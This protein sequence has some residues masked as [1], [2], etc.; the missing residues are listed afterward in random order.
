MNDSRLAHARQKI[1]ERINSITERQ[2][3]LELERVAIVT[4]LAGFDAAINI[5]HS[6]QPAEPGKKAPEFGS[7]RG[8]DPIL[9]GDK[10]RK[11]MEPD[12]VQRSTCDFDGVE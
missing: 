11:A 4:E 12:N 5:M 3:S 6:D 9:H 7:S 2:K 1:V 10:Y 8:H